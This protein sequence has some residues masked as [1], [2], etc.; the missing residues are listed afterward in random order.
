MG[1]ARYLSRRPLRS[2][3]SVSIALRGSVRSFNSQRRRFL[4]TATPSIKAARIKSTSIAFSFQ[5][6]SVGKHS[7]DVAQCH[8]IAVVPIDVLTGSTVLKASLVEYI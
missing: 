6:G 4:D 3:I 7:H 2:A 5:F 8:R 1:Q